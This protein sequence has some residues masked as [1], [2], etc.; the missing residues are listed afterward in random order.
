M[1]SGAGRGEHEIGVSDDGLRSTAAARSKAG[2]PGPARAGARRNRVRGSLGRWHLGEH[3]RARYRENRQVY[4]ST[5]RGLLAPA[6]PR[7]PRVASS[8]TARVTSWRPPLRTSMSRPSAIGSPSHPNPRRQKAKAA[9]EL[10]DAA[11]A[12]GRGD[13]LADLVGLPFPP[14]G[15]NRCKRRLLARALRRG[16]PPGDGTPPGRDSR[17]R[18][19]HPPPPGA[20]A[21][22]GLLVTALPVGSPERRLGRGASGNDLPR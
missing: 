22:L 8:G 3:V 10:P 11:L 2:S 15:S 13:P 21:P 5:L 18:W 6:R 1:E 17:P 14:T 16:G 7:S 9:A 12:Q 19:P 20:G 4:V